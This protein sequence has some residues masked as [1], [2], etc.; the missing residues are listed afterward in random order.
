MAKQKKTFTSNDYYN[1]SRAK[2]D[3]NKDLREMLDKTENR[4]IKIAEKALLCDKMQELKIS[5]IKSG[6]LKKEIKGYKLSKVSR[7]L[8]SIATA[9][10]YFGAGLSTAFSIDNFVNGDITKAGMFLTI[11][12]ASL[13]AGGLM[14]AANNDSYAAKAE[15]DA[16]NQNKA[17]N[18][19]YEKT[20]EQE[21]LQKEIAYL[22]ASTRELP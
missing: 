20:Q 19:L 18:L 14:H 12:I 8:K 5:E 22:E 7:V 13:A 1:D 10:W 3:L 17:E 16:E 11:S 6:M 21:I 9:I 2:E 4:D 15:K